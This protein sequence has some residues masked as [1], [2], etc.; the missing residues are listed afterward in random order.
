[1]VQK[2]TASG[3]DFELAQQWFADAKRPLVVSGVEAL[4]QHAESDIANFCEQFNLPLITSYKGKGILSEDHPL[5]LGGAG[6]S[7]K[8]NKVLLP[9]MQQADVVILAGYD[10]IE[11]R[12]EWRNPWSEN[13]KII[14]LVTLPNTH[15]MHQADISFECDIAST[16]NA[17][18]D[19]RQTKGEVWSDG[20][21]DQTRE[22]LSQAF[23]PG[24]EWGPGQLIS[25]ARDI[26]PRDTVGAV[27]TGAHRILLSQMWQC[28]QPHTPDA[29]FC[30]VY[31]GLCR[32]HGVG[33]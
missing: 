8:A 30:I 21:I 3:T 32:T 14:E 28:Y 5:A 12:N 17:L 26:M 23:D 16:I 9:F 33:L 18:G 25:L 19:K 10:P 22:Q 20:Q 13:A 4:Y 11:M 31:H 6:L 7:P 29:I 2:G 27:D 1:M 15:Y 24:Q